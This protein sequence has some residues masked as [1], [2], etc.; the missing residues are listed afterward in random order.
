MKRITF[1]LTVIIAF[2]WLYK[3]SDKK[4]FKIKRF[5][6]SIKIAFIIAAAILGMPP[7]SSAEEMGNAE[8]N[9]PI[10]KVQNSAV[11]RGG[12]QVKPRIF[13]I[14]ANIKFSTCVGSIRYN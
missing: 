14:P 7:T 2:C 12:F 1:L 11:Q 6:Q 4:D 13:N 9:T 8:T 10:E 3:T 5:T